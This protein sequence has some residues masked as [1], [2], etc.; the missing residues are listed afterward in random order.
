MNECTTDYI[1]KGYTELSPSEFLAKL[2]QTCP[3]ELPVLAMEFCA[4][5]DLRTQLQAI[6]NRNGFKENEVKNMLFC[7]RNAVQYLHSQNITHRDI[8]PENIVIKNVEGRRIY[9]L[10]D[11]GYAKN[12]DANTIQASLV[13]TRDYFAPEIITEFS[14]KNTVDYWSVGVIAFEIICGVRPF[15]PHQQL[16][17]CIIQI[18]KKT[19][20]HIAITEV[21]EGGSYKFHERLFK[22]NRCSQVFQVG[23]FKNNFQDRIEKVIKTKFYFM[24]SSNSKSYYIFTQH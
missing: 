18:S 2:N 20:K 10:T 13:G 17:T 15:I 19:N 21:P 7:L 5:G 16:H 8:K 24:Y 3:K 22:E 6:E 23:F 1:V 9:K 12:I 11:M 4:G 14:Y